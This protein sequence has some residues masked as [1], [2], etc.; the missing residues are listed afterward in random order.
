MKVNVKT[1]EGKQFD[2]TFEEDETVSLPRFLFF[3]CTKV[4]Q[5]QQ[6]IEEQQNIPSDQQK[7]IYKGKMMTERSKKVVEYQVKDGDF[8]VIMVSKVQN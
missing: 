1:L 3:I 8:L 5:L 2:V 7:L 4:A 6:R